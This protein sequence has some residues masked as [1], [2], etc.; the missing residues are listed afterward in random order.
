MA[1]FAYLSFFH[2]FQ[3]LAPF[4]P[5]LF[6]ISNE[7]EEEKNRRYGSIGLQLNKMPTT[8]YPRSA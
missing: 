5:R 3:S 1:L 7:R 6:Q 2:P 4:M 8:K